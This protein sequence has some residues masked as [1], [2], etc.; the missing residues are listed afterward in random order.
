VFVTTELQTTFHTEYAGMLT[1]H[2]QNKSYYPRAHGSFSNR[3][4]TKKLS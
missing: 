3:Y 4:Q 2:I 1:F